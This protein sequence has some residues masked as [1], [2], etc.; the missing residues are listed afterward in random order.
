MNN[1]PKN[2]DESDPD[3]L[4]KIESCTPTYSMD[5]MVKT[6]VSLIPDNNEFDS[7]NDSLDHKIIY[8]QIGHQLDVDIPVTIIHS[9][10]VKLDETIEGM[11]VLCSIDDE[12]FI[13]KNVRIYKIKLIPSEDKKEKKFIY[14]V[15]I[16]NSP[17][18]ED[19]EAFIFQTSMFYFMT[20]ETFDKTELK[21]GKQQ[22]PILDII[23]GKQITKKC[24]CSIINGDSKNIKWKNYSFRYANNVND[25]ID[26]QIINFGIYES[27]KV[28]E[29][30]MIELNKTLKIVK[31][32]Q[33]N[34]SKSY[35]IAKDEK[36]NISFFEDA[37]DEKNNISWFKDAADKMFGEPE[38]PKKLTIYTFQPQN[39]EEVIIFTTGDKS[40]EYLFGTGEY[41]YTNEH[42]GGKTCR[43]RKKKISKKISKK[44]PSRKTK[45]RR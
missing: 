21:K 14:Y 32:F 27:K 7:W 36:N 33:D 22:L 28:N 4:D 45:R 44:K 9:R 23:P 3:N 35:T 2:L 34:N 37:E 17:I 5:S 31:V 8:D 42:T 20:G 16:N 1:D 40:G 26:G 25:F 15:T 10:F 29:K 39:K 6:I 12:K 11:S 24:N 13:K 18:L 41:Y 19:S 30:E 43:N 38:K